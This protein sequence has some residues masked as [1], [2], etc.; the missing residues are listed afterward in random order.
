MITM[1]AELT[2][3]CTPTII[4]SKKCNSV[5]RNRKDCYILSSYGCDGT[6][7]VGTGGHG[8]GSG[9]SQED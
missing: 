9:I 2:L 4:D 1:A 7:M 5:D 3:Y 8:W 6:A